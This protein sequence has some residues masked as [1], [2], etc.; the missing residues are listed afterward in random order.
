MLTTLP[1]SDY[2]A[3]A[4][5]YKLPNQKV[6][7]WDQ[8]L[9]G[10][11]SYYQGV[12]QQV[13][14]VA[15]Y[16]ISQAYANYKQQQLQLQMANQLGTGFK[17]QV[18]SQLQSQYGEAFQ[19]VKTQEASALADVQS[20]YATA[21]E[22]GEQQF[23]QLGKMLKTYDTLIKEYAEELQMNAPE[24][25]TKTTV[26]KYG[27]TTT[28]LTD[29]GR[30]WYSDVLGATTNEGLN[31]DQWLF[32]EASSSDLSVEDREAFWDAYRQN[33]ALFREQVAGLTSDFDAAETRTRLATEEKQT[34]WNA[35]KNTSVVP[36]ALVEIHGTE[37][38]NI[39]PEQA[40]QIQSNIDRNESYV[41]TMNTSNGK[42]GDVVE[43]E[44][45]NKWRLSGH[46]L[47]GEKAR[48][49]GKDLGIL[50][51]KGYVVDSNKYKTGDVIYVD[52]DYYVIQIEKSKA[53]LKGREELAGIRKLAPGDY[54]HEGAVRPL[55]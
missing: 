37:F 12:A 10:Q 51:D 19:D 42:N 50:D 28:E 22:K 47:V 9:T 18:G 15:S 4:K 25:A 3:L 17:E 35:I 36:D 33:P 38:T 6:S 32:S 2:T 39:T 16:D 52:G 43:D 54:S 11:Q 53:F 27:V 13:S 40:R 8:F 34:A 30:L 5:E 55:F 7:L 44:Y 46:N 26:D 31:F 23:T 21:V 41:S 1:T 20:Q 48:S 49:L 24:N 14:D 29:Y 45:G